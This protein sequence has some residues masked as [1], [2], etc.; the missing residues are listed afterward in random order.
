[1]ARGKKAT[2]KADQPAETMVEERDQAVADAIKQAKRVLGQPEEQPSNVTS[3]FKKRE[4]PADRVFELRGWN[5][6]IVL[7]EG[8]TTKSHDQFLKGISNKYPDLLEVGEV[9]G[10]I[11]DGMRFNLVRTA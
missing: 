3:I 2:G 9:T 4:I 1:M 6:G 8:I 5:S 7:Q 11:I 10:T